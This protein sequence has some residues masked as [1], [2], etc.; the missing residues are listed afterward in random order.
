MFAD[1]KSQSATSRSRVEGDGSFYGRGNE[2]GY[3]A[4]RNSENT[5]SDIRDQGEAGY[6]RQ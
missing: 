5:E 4:C 2:R 1:L 6:D 3:D